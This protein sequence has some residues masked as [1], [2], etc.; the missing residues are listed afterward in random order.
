MRNARSHTT[1]HCA[2]ASMS[3][4]LAEFSTPS[5]PGIRDDTSQR[6]FMSP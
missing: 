2:S 1:E 5:R 6:V 3:G 4:S